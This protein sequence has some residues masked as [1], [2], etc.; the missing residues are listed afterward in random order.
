MPVEKSELFQEKESI[1]PIRRKNRIVNLDM[2]ELSLD[3][4]KE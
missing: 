4:F 2:M 3:H 1:E